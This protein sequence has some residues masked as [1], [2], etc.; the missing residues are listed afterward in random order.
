MKAETNI[1]HIAPAFHSQGGGIF[2]VVDNLSNAQGEVKKTLVHV[3][4]TLTCG[5]Q[6]SENRTV[7]NLLPASF[8]QAF[9][10]FPL[11]KWIFNEI[12]SMNH[13]HIHGAWS[14]QLFFLVPLLL[15]FKRKITYQPHGLLSPVCM[16][17][18]WFIKKT[19]WFLYQ[20]YYLFFSKNVICCSDKERQ[21][22]L[23][24]SNNSQKIS[25]VF[26]GLHKSF[27]ETKPKSSSRKNRLLFVSQVTPIKNLEN[28]FHALAMRKQLDGVNDCIDIYG[29][30]PSDYID[31][32]K[33]LVD[34]LGLRENVKFLGPIARE[35]RVDVYDDYKYFILA[36]LSENFGI[37][38]LEALSRR[39]QVLVSSQTPWRDFEHSDL[40][41]IDPDKDSIYEALK[42]IMSNDVEIHNPQ[43]DFEWQGL[44]DRFQWDGVVQKINSLYIS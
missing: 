20:N 21:E 15:I 42:S 8:S 10:L 32:L 3:L 4:C 2:E 34:Q 39:C 26:N 7:H 43:R 27:F 36:S 38:V 35:K 12:R 14:F 33:K 11:L 25:I 41:V 16:Q 13:I 40:T 29:Y 24:L 37:V 17:K 31:S 44:I 22:L 6:S 1:L 28:I 30:G 19:A 9:L 5:I 18:N 23:L